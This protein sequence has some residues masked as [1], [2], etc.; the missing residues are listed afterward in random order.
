MVYEFVDERGR[1]YGT[2]PTYVDGIPANPYG[3][4]LAVM[5]KY[6]LR[7]VTFVLRCVD[8]T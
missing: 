3:R 6:N 2:M 1:V 8:L 4:A 7:T 5:L